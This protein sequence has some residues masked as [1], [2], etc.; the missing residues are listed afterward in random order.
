LSIFGDVYSNSL[1]I[2]KTQDPDATKVGQIR[3]E[4]LDPTDKSYICY[5]I[6]G[7]II[8]KYMT[9]WQSKLLRILTEKYQKD[10]NQWVDINFSINENLMTL[11]IVSELFNGK[12]KKERQ[13]MVENSLKDLVI[14][15]KQPIKRTP[16][17]KNIN[18]L[19]INILSSYYTV[20]EAINIFENKKYSYEDDRC[21]DWQDMANRAVN[22]QNYFYKK[23]KNISTYGNVNVYYSYRHYNRKAKKIYRDAYELVDNCKKVVIIDFCFEYSE[24][25]PLITAKERPKLG[26]IKYLH[27]RLYSPKEYPYEFKDF[28]STKEVNGEYKDMIAGK[29]VKDKGVVY[30]FDSSI[31][32][33]DYIS[34][35]ENIKPYALLDSGFNLCEVLIEDIDTNMKPDHILI[36]APSGLSKWTS[37]LVTQLADKLI[38]FENKNTLNDPIIEVVNRC[39]DVMQ[40]EKE[41]IYYKQ[42]I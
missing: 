8:E 31:L 24:L 16:I 25:N 13:T 39:I 9:S 34:Y 6:W 3:I 28:Y 30:T 5:I 36:N 11:T 17:T 1:R 4:V 41:T 35:L 18:E 19:E 12:T 21:I 10:D 27:D 40:L 29:I 15:V 32:N 42:T 26:I 37:L 2:K 23:R 14:N 33:L 7:I 22:P 20:E 38:L